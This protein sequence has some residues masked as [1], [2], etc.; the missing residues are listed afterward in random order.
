MEK[1]REYFQQFVTLSNADWEAFSSK[2]EKAEFPKKSLILKKGQTENYLSFI[3][4]GII[5]YFIPNIESDLTFGFT[6]ENEFVSAYDSFLTRT[7]SPY[8]LETLTD[9]KLWRISYQGLQEVYQET[10]V[11]NIIGRMA[12][13]SLYLKKARRELAFLNQTAKERYLSLFSE[14]PELIKQIPLK[15]I[16]SYIGI[17]PQ[18]LSRIR[19]RI[20]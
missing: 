1:I 16:A 17:T 14:R 19:K 18:A 13:E 7:A 20:S 9:S 6:F 15:Y 3:D 10:E 4:K 11:G 12:A 2:L 8:N 5:R